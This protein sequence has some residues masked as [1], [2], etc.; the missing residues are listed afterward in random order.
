MNLPQHVAIIMDG[1]G[2]WAKQRLLPRVAGHQ[3]GAESAR[4]I[5]TLCVK[6]KIPYLTLFAFSSENWRR[7][8]GEV[9]FL[10]DLFL[11][12]L[13]N[14]IQE[15]HKNQIRLKIV[16]DKA[17]FNKEFQ[18]AI[19]EAEELTRNNSGL[20]LNIALNYG[21]R[22]DILQAVQAISQK[23]ADGEMGPQM[24]TEEHFRQQLTLSDCPE[25]DFL[26]RTS[27]EYRISNFLL[28]QFAYTELYF[29][30]T[31][32][33]DFRESQFEEAMKAYA[34]RQRR[35]GYISEQVESRP[36]DNV[37]ELSEQMHA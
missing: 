36:Q 33:P 29:T 30:D 20:Q 6:K 22:W 24:I 14:E 9:R 3:R 35:F 13:K 11:R 25:P 37:D 28:W 19:F 17:R 23:V 8:E 2:R 4:A 32:W 21:G 15:L 26:I 27:G 34:E 7:P 10:L 16:G 12:S 31:L 1:N 5:I 18:I